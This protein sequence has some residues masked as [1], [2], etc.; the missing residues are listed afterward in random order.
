MYESDI[1]CSPIF[2]KRKWFYLH[3]LI[4]ALHHFSALPYR[5]G[6]L[7]K[8]I[9]LHTL[10]ERREEVRRMVG[11]ETKLGKK[12]KWTKSGKEKKE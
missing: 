12:K 4:Q 10:I 3:E 6:H 7:L 1:I 2:A 9:Y 11:N 8:I 5:L